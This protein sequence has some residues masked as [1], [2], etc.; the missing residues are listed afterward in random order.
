MQLHLGMKIRE[1]RHR[2]GRTQEMLADALGITSQAVSRWES[3]GS[4][5]DMEM[6]PSIANYFGITIDELFGYQNDREQ[7]ILAILEK[8]KS[9]FRSTGGFLGKETPALQEC[10]EILRAANEE[11]PGESRILLRL[12]DTLF[13]LGWD[14]KDAPYCQEA[15]SIYERLYKENLSSEQRDAVI[16][17]LVML[18]QRQGYFE[19]AKSLAEKQTSIHL[20]REVLLAKTTSGDEQESYR[21]EL[22][23]ALL[24]EMNAVL[25]NSILLNPELSS[26]EYGKEV[27]YAL[28][29]LYEVICK[30][31]R[32]GAVHTNLRYL[33]LTL[34]NLEAR[35]EAHMD[36]ALICFDKGFE[37]H[38]EYCNI[39]STADYNY[40]APLLSKV[41]LP[42]EKIQPVPDFF[43]QYHMDMVPDSLKD[44]LRK[45]PK[46][47]ECFS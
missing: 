33:Y 23:L 36:K 14:K 13:F 2:D 19:K 18:Y 35:S 20:C 22:I 10:L 27:L 45:N 29:N 6:I 32:C 25:A 9:G 16:L 1:L 34:A 46:Y 24:N 38:K 12:A 39:S 8:T 21:G 3:G 30:D 17:N 31:G 7:K 43:W 42:T 44:E 4:Y 28:I 26:S 15:L 47:T 5:P 41:V 11:Y 40:T 37:H